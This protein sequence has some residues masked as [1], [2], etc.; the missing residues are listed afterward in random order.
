MMINFNQNYYRQNEE[1]LFE[2]FLS[3]IEKKGDYLVMYFTTI[4]NNGWQRIFK[5]DG[6][7]LIHVCDVDE[8]N[9]WYIFSATEDVNKI[10]REIFEEDLLL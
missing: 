2:E 4:N 9:Q 6:D 7:A 10:K 1:G 8:G 3:G 5:I